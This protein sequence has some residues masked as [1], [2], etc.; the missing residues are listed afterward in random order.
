M[1]T[2]YR[3]R[4]DAGRE[5]AS[6][7]REYADRSDVIVL[8]LPRGGVP[9]AREVANALHAPL[10]LINVRKLGTPGAP[11]LAMG[12]I[13]TGGVRVLN[14][15]VIGLAGVTPEQIEEA[16]QVETREL[17][18]R[19]QLYRSGRPAPDVSGRTVI[20][21]DDGVATGSTMKAA[22]RALRHQTPKRIVVAVPVGAGDTCRQLQV[23]ADRVICPR[24]PADFVAIGLFYAAF[25]QLTD[26]EVRAL[27]E[28][29]EPAE[30]PVAMSGNS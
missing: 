13:A 18:R 15:S 7:L 4:E 29:S 2:A 17:E 6:A 22:V 9:V 21:V 8:A 28:F 12:A 3:N 25:P 20:L 26:D 24:M 19:E 11:E 14:H 30:D 27:M 10:D 16:V 1:P 5:L 23:L